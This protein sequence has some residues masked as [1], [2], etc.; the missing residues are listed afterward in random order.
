MIKLESEISLRGT[1]QELY[2]LNL[3]RILKYIILMILVTKT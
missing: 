2:I 3:T 1:I